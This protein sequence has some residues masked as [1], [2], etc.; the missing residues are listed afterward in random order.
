[1][2]P[3]TIEWVLF[4]LAYINL[5]EEKRRTRMFASEARALAWAS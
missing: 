4:V 5:A 1:M 3:D 2:Y